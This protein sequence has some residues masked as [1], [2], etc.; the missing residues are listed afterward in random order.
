M[1]TTFNKLKSHFE[2]LQEKVFQARPII[3]ELAKENSHISFYEYTKQCNVKNENKIIKKRLDS[4]TRV[5]K[6]EVERMYGK[7]IA[8]SVVAQLQYNSSMS[9]AQHFGALSTSYTLNPTLQNAL[10]YFG[11]SDPAFQNVIVL[12]CTGVSFDNYSFP[13]GHKFH[14]LFNHELSLQQL[15]F[16]GRAVDP[17]PTLFFKAYTT[18]SVQK[19]KA[20]LLELRTTGVI[21]RKIFEDLNRFFDDVYAN[22]RILSIDNYVDQM[23][24]SMISIWKKMFESYNESV[25][26]LVVLS[27]EKV[28]LDLLLAYHL[29]SDTTI[30]RMLFDQKYLDL[31]DAHFDTIQGAFNKE[32]GYGTYLFWAR[33]PGE[34]HRVQ[35]IRKGDVLTTKDGSYQISLTPDALRSAIEQNQLIPSLM[36]T[37]TVL[38]LYYGFILTGGLDQPTYLT[39]MKNAYIQ[40]LTAMGDAESVE[41]C[42]DLQT[43][44]LAITRPTLAFLEGAGMRV[45]ATGLDF[46]LHENGT[47]SL[48]GILDASKRITLQEVIQ[49]IL[50]I[51][52]PWYYEGKV[53]DP[54]LSSITEKDIEAIIGSKN[55]IPAWATIA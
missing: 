26:N 44:N 24:F 35:L 27:Q 42:M 14:A 29:E 54:N 6:K 28:V 34:T 2:Q 22:E 21:D 50:P 36:L 41:A 11:C 4:F 48:S 5:F 23:H 45:P 33:P 9:T 18:E 19:I 8:G 53:L 17:Y 49:R 46:Y 37:F 47:D 3:A 43:H 7:K 52:Y 10:A 12:D 31:I 20:K 13:R 40:I 30:H 16:W 39:Q 15:P 1:A 38:A 32:T 55:R 51:L 25:P